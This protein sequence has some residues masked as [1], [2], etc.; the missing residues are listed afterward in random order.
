MSKIVSRN[1]ATGEI[2]REFEQTSPVHLN[3]VFVKSR[4]A[5][6][7]WASYSLKKRAYYLILLREMLLNQSEEI[8]TIISS[9][10]GKPRF[11]ALTHEVLPSVLLLT[12]FAK[13]GPKLLRDKKLSTWSVPYRKSYLNYWPLG[14]VAV[15]SPWNYP[16]MLPFTQ[17]ALSLMAGNSVIL[18]PSEVTPLSGIKIQELCELAGLPVGIVQT[19][20][21]DGTLGA[22]LIDQKPGK[23]F[24]IGSPSTGRKIMEAASKHLIPVSLELGG[25]NPMI[26]LPD[27]DLDFASSAALWGAYMN[28]GQT[29]AQTGRIIIHESI[30]ELFV[31]KFKEKA[32]QLRQGAPNTSEGLDLGVATFENQKTVYESHIKD[33]KDRGAHFDLGGEMSSDRKFLKPTLVSGSNIEN[34]KAYLDETFGPLVALTTYKSIDEAVQKANQNQYGLTASI[35]TK[36]ASFGE[37]IAKRL[38]AGGIA[39]NEAAS[40]LPGMPEAPWGGLKESGFGRVRSDDSIY[41]FVHIRHINRPKSRLFVFKSLWWVPYTDGQYT[42]ITSFMGL[43]R[44]HYID[45]ARALPHFLWNLI[46][47]LKTE[48]RF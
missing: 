48:R 31:L 12:H 32:A 18:K 27:A 46:S 14:V 9:E 2:L 23:I 7:K 15:I 35:I 34:T 40:V 1:P 13:R 44:R 4:E 41:E 33:A 6:I 19:I 11:E 21:G 8:A 36:N 29:C 30:A 10:T 42:L 22:A 16:F 24:F 5:Q 17:I 20:L 45:K 39:I 47:L 28:S 37:E 25:K 26:I 3:E 43:F 38:E